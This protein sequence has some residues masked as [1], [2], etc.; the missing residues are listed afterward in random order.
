MPPAQTKQDHCDGMESTVLAISRLIPVI[1]D[2]VKDLSCG[3]KIA[4]SCRKIKVTM[5]SDSQKPNT[6][7]IQPAERRNN[8]KT[9][10]EVDFQNENGISI[11]TLEATTT[12]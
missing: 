9:R 1:S 5:T 6:G 7:Y 12:Q 11:F 3:P 8:E 2:C 10:F 4:A